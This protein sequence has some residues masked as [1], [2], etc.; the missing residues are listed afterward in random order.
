MTLIITGVMS[1]PM[2]SPSMA[3]P[4][5]GLHGENAVFEGDGGL[6]IAHASHLLA[7]LEFSPPISRQAFAKHQDG[8]F[9]A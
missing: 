9:T 5:V 1:M 2:P 7:V 4:W 6:A 3:E 8:R